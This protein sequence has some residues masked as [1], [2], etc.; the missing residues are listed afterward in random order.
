MIEND[1]KYTIV[2]LFSGAGG[3]TIGF[4]KAYYNI[5]LSTDFDEDWE[6]AHHNKRAMITSSLMKD[7]IS[8]GKG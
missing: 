8:I 6:K 3:F 4:T 5:L 7:M 2:D 1:S